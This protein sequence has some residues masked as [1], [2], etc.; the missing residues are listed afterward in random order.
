MDTC[1]YMDIPE[2]HLFRAPLLM[3]RIEGEDEVY[4]QQ[5]RHPCHE[6]LKNTQQW[7]WHSKINIIRVLFISKHVLVS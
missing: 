6:K 1:L 5:T 7:S 4:I 2:A 3:I